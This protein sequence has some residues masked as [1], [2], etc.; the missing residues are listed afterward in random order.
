LGIVSVEEL[1][2]QREKVRVY[3]LARELNVESKDLLDMCRQA[4]FDVKNQLSSLDPEQR[5]AIEH[6]VKR[7]GGSVAV[8]PPPPKPAAPV[9]PTVTTPIRNLNA[10]PT[11]REP[12]APRPAP[13]PPPPTAAPAVQPVR[14]VD[15]IP[16]AA[17]PRPPAPAAPAEVPAS[18]P[19]VPEV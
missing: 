15:R 11:R 5:D 7:G 17:A 13:A 4:G 8:A 1:R 14:P 6:L 3:A 9:L 12:E 2:L 16:P 10:R 18:A 19:N